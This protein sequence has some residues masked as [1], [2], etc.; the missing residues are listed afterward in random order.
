MNFIMSHYRKKHKDHCYPVNSGYFLFWTSFILKNIDYFTVTVFQA[1][2]STQQGNL[3]GFI[4]IF[5]LFFYTFFH[6]LSSDHLV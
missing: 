4:L 6:S 3:H 5:N 1:R 2:S